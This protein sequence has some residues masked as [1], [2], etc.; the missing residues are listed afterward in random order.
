MLSSTRRELP[1]N[2]FELCGTLSGKLSFPS[3]PHPMVNQQEKPRG[4]L[5]GISVDYSPGKM[6]SIA[7][8]NIDGFST[9]NQNSRVILIEHGNSVAG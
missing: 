5:T 2:Q 6:E 9:H 7:S 8:F 4:C 1:D 3:A